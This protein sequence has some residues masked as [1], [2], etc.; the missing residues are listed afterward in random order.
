MSRF[1]EEP[2]ALNENDVMKKQVAELKLSL[3]AAIETID[4]CGISFSEE[5]MKLAR[6]REK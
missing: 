6:E 2:D 4:A 3:R 1:D 5:S